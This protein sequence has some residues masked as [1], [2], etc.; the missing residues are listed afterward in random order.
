MM[1]THC[2]KVLL[3]NEIQWLQWDEIAVNFTAQRKL[4]RMIA[5]T[6][7][8]SIDVNVQ[9]VLTTAY[10]FGND[11]KEGGRPSNRKVDRNVVM[12]RDAM[13]SCFNWDFLKRRGLLPR[14]WKMDPWKRRF[15]FGNHHFQVPCWGSSVDNWI[16]RWKVLQEASCWCHHLLVRQDWGVHGVSEIWCR[17]IF[18]WTFSACWALDTQSNRAWELRICLRCKLCSIWFS[19]L[20]I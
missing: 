18:L 13:P 7:M 9:S 14:T 6:S 15:L 16:L 11:L 3:T 4:H 20:M 17:I 5:G 12:Q 2:G 8:P 19:I 10:V 1:T